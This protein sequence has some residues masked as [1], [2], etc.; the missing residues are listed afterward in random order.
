MRPIANLSWIALIVLLLTAG[1]G[2]A[3]AHSVAQAAIAG[4]Y[5]V[6]LKGG[7]NA[8]AAIASAQT[9]GGDVFATYDHAI[10]G[11]AAALPQAALAAVRADARTRFVAEDRVVTA[12]AQ[13]LPFNVDRVDGELSSTAPVTAPAPSSV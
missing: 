7:A 8:P 6:V 9:L 3:N 11:Y 1:L 10:H 2:G 5:I 12:T 4:P 13:T